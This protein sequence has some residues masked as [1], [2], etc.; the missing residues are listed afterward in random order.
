[1]ETDISVKV[2][3]EGNIT[4]VVPELENKL[5]AEKASLL[6]ALL[7]GAIEDGK[8]LADKWSEGSAILKPYN[9]TGRKISEVASKVRAIPDGELPKG[10]IDD[11]VA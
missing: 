7:K 2:S 6:V 10:V 5:S 3:R 9:S 4:M 8:E 1:M 11:E